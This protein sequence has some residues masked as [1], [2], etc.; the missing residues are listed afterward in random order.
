[1]GFRLDNIQK[2]FF[3]SWL[4]VF[5]TNKTKQEEMERITWLL[6]PGHGGMIP[7]GEGGLKYA[8]APAKMHT[9]DDGFVLYEGVFNRQVIQFVKDIMKAKGMKYID[10]VDSE[11]DI[12]L[13][14]RVQKANQF[15]VE[16]KRCAYF[17][18][19]GNAANT[20]AH[21]IEIYT[22]KGETTSDKYATVIL[23]EIM[24][25]FPD[26]KYRLD[27]WSDGDIDKEANYFVLKK[28][29]MP[30]VLLEMWFFDNR[31]D[32]EKMNNPEM[33]RRVAEA[34]VRAFESIEKQF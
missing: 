23:E 9:F 21:G 33:R 4:K 26:E 8:T 19:H 3:L 27:T 29:A 16:D 11:Y 5:F 2:S 22:S 13:G 34:I 20:K 25:E 31:E 18:M 30:A 6:D 24:K 32:A 12:P 14:D 28:T 7:D 15:Y 17:S 10:V 1:M